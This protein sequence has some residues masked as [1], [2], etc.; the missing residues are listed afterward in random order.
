MANFD[1]PEKITE[2]NYEYILEEYKE[3]ILSYEKID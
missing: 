3:H 2:E 1:I